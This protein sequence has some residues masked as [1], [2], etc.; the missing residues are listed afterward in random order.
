MTTRTGLYIVHDGKRV[1][2]YTQEEFNRLYN[3]NV[4][5]SKAKH[6]IKEWIK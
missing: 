1:N 5:W 2:V 6:N 3:F 4:W